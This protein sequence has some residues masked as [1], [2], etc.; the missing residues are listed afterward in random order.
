MRQT[1]WVCPHVFPQHGIS[2]VFL[3]EGKG[4][5]FSCFC[6]KVVNRESR[7]VVETEKFTLGILRLV[8]FFGS[9][10]KK[11]NSMSF[12]AWSFSLRDNSLSEDGFS[13]KCWM[14][15]FQHFVFSAGGEVPEPNVSDRK[16]VSEG[17]AGMVFGNFSFR[18][19]LS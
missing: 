6:G 9:M 2:I 11:K 17:I 14:F 7:N 13:K 5:E 1:R 16:S 4:G 15:I 12:R 19:E 10:E 3:G 8:Y 18:K